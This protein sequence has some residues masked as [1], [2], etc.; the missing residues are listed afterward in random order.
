M[1]ILFFAKPNLGKPMEIGTYE[2]SLG[3]T[4][5]IIDKRNEGAQ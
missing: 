5:L 3:K 4:K 1:N 2:Q